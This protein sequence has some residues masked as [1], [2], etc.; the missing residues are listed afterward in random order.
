MT[1]EQDKVIEDYYHKILKHMN[2]VATHPVMKGIPQ[3]QE[4]FKEI[5][6]A[7]IEFRKLTREAL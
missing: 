5:S 7:L 1:P 4:E 3:L 2:K 6:L